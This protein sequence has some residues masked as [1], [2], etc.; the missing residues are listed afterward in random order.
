[1]ENVRLEHKGMIHFI[2]SHHGTNKFIKPQLHFISKNVKSEYKIWAF[3]DGEDLNDLKNS[4]HFINHPEN[5]IDGYRNEP[6]S[7]DAH[8]K[9]L[10]KL[11]ELAWNR[12]IPEDDIIVFLDGDAFPIAPLDEYLEDVLITHSFAAIQRL[13]S[14][15]DIQ[16]CSMFCAVKAGLWNEVGASWNYKNYSWYNDHFGSYRKDVG[17]DLLKLA[18]EKR[19][20]W[21]PLHRTNKV[22]IHPV[23]F[24][25]YDNIIYHHGAGFRGSFDGFYLGKEKMDLS[26]SKRDQAIA[27]EKDIFNLNEFYNTL[28]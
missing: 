24:G 2:T 10:D 3:Y 19:L 12:D 25:I 26:Y 1:M 16:P 21:W 11:F 6:A 20:V 28:I 15:F 23:G 14:G 22:N 17:G 13:E 7:L 27:L 9:K 18:F 5:Y 8:Y 4:F